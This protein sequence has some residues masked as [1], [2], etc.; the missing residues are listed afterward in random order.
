MGIIKNVVNLQVGIYPLRQLNRF[1]NMNL[2]NSLG[3][4]V[5]YAVTLFAFLILAGCEG[6]LSTDSVTDDTE[7]T[8]RLDEAFQEKAYIRLNHDG[9][10]DDY[11]CYIVTQDMLSDAAVLL[12]EH[13]AATLVSAG[14]I[15]VGTGTNKN[16]T[17]GDLQPKTSYRM[18]AARVLQDGKITGNVA[19]LVF[20]TLRNP[21]VFEVHPEWEITY[22]ERRVA[23]DDLNVESE[24]FDCS[25]GEGGDTYV[26]CL[27]SKSD[28][29]SSYGGNLRACFEDYV[30]FRNLQHVKWPNVVTAESCEHLEDR[31]RH[32]DYIVFMIGIDAEGEL[33]GWY[34]RTD[35]TI[36]Q[37]K[38]TDAYRRWIGKWELKGTCGEQTI[39][40][41]VEIAPDENNLYYRMYGWEADTATNY[42]AELPTQRPILLYFEKSSGDAYVV[43]EEIADFE[44]PTLAEFY[45][46]FV[47]GCVEIDYYG[48][49]T[50]VPVDIPNLRI[51]RF[52]LVNDNRAK[53][54]P[55]IFSFDL[56]GVHYEAPFIYFSYSYI[57]ALYQGLVPVTVDSVVPRISTMTLSR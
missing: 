38:A 57:S 31:L 46:F 27:L 40:Y 20:A 5:V 51:A 47:Y 33:T 39:T 11:W 22:K 56:N 34:A 26:P 52:S 53:V 30:A 43:S 24:V 29:E 1:M 10:Q 36:E 7:V 9:S 8:L 19:E 17:V 14:E 18:I 41:Q 16:I 45:D 54:A 42:F 12:K 23:A 50:E 13:I 44:D 48:E 6:K 25:A 49:M 32:G 15:E 35:V 4:T 28:F 21:D 3:R 55:E 2:L 37:E